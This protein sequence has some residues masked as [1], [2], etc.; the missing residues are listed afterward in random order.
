MLHCQMIVSFFFFLTIK[1]L[2]KECTFFRHKAF[3]AHLIY[4]PQ[5]SVNIN[6]ICTKKTQNSFDSSYCD[7]CF[8][9]VVWTLIH[10]IS[11][12]CLI[13]PRV[14]SGSRETGEPFA[15]GHPPTLISSSQQLHQGLFPDPQVAHWPTPS[16]WWR[17]TNPRGPAVGHPGHWACPL[18][19][20]SSCRAC[21]C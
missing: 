2:T 1:S 17:F 3:I 6:F 18:A 14:A 5:D 19:S 9:V 16:G 15:S 4:G 12:V 20:W 7:I 10:S 8:I 21:P 11:E 13:G